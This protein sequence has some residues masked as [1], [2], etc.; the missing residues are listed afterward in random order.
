MGDGWA[1]KVSHISGSGCVR[2][3]KRTGTMLTLWPNSRTNIHILRIN[4]M[5][6]CPWKWVHDDKKK[7]MVIS[8][9]RL[10]NVRE[11]TYG[12]IAYLIYVSRYVIWGPTHTQACERK[13]LMRLTNQPSEQL[14]KNSTWFLSGWIFLIKPISYIDFKT[15]SATPPPPAP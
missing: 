7:N 6:V 8:I 9:H 13:G 4:H 3:K 15:Q 2:E 5:H 11:W 14:F 10:D 12:S 1:A